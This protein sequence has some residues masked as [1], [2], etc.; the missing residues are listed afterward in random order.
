MNHQT[1]LE[2]AIVCIK[3]FL[4]RTQNKCLISLTNLID[5]STVCI[6][7]P[8]LYFI[9]EH[10][11]LHKATFPFTSLL[12]VTAAAGRA[13]RD[14]FI[15]QNVSVMN[16]TLAESLTVPATVA[17]CNTVLHLS[18]NMLSSNVDV[19]SNAGNMQTPVKHLVATLAVVCI[20]SFYIFMRTIVIIYFAYIYNFPYCEFAI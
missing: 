8:G 15:T 1:D 5:V 7:R 2:H 19:S 9:W 4:S 3:M 20:F 17:D 11:H 10:I 13:S 16:A 6:C 14:D 12:E 18:L